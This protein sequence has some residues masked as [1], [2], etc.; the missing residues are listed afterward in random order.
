MPDVGH[1]ISHQLT[2]T[3]LLPANSQVII[4][5]VVK[6]LTTARLLARQHENR[7]GGRGTR[8]GG[9]RMQHRAAGPTRGNARRWQADWR[10]TGRA[11]SVNDPKMVCVRCQIVGSRITKGNDSGGDNVPRPKAFIH[12]NLVL[13]S[14]PDVLHPIAV[15]PTVSARV[16]ESGAEQR[17][18]VPENLLSQY[19]TKLTE[20]FPG[21]NLAMV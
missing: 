1:C 4:F 12:F 14:R 19:S 13:L 11:E 18:A 7:F 6:Q 9:G 15:T 2:G 20:S 8:E 10:I 21:T 17:K 16:L 5:T 3:I